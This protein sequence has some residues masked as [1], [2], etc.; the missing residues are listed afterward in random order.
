MPSSLALALT[1]VRDL[2]RDRAAIGE[3]PV[4]LDPVGGPGWR[5]CR[6]WPGNWPR[7][8]VL[9]GQPDAGTT[10]LFLLSL[11]VMAVLAG[12]TSLSGIRRGA[13]GVGQGVLTVLARGGPVSVPVVSTLSRLLARLEGD[14]DDAFARYTAAVLAPGDPDPFPQNLFAEP[15]DIAEPTGTPEHTSTVE[16]AGTAEHTDTVEVADTVGRGGGVAAGAVLRVASLDGKG[17]RGSRDGHRQGPVPGVGVSGRT[18]KPLPRGRQIDANSKRGHRVPGGLRRPTRPG[19]PCRGHLTPLP[20]RREHAR[21]LNRRDRFALFLVAQNR[22]KLFAASD[23]LPWATIPVGYAEEGESP[24]CHERR[25]TK[26]LPAPPGPPGP[27]F[28]YAM[29]VIPVER[30][31]TGCGDDRTHAVVAPCPG[32][33]LSGGFVPCSCRQRPTGHGLSR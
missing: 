32:R 26:V 2:A 21:Y 8:P 1:L 20:T 27:P 12:A 13:T 28:P 14:V 15:D 10:W 29:Q 16:V 31:A 9:G 25:V 22:P 24:G 23:A 18:R 6:S 30:I 7:P 5:W 3:V 4:V 17:V 33:H 11:V 19:R